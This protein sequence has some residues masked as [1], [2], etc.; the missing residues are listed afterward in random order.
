MVDKIGPHS[1]AGFLVTEME[2]VFP[3]ASASASNKIFSFL[4]I[5]KAL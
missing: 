2:S 1:V 3:I 4:S 5:F